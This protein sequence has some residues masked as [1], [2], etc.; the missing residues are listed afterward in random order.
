MQT[1]AVIAIDFGPQG[2]CAAGWIRYRVL[3]V[4]PRTALHHRTGQ[5]HHGASRLP[6]CGRLRLRQVSSLMCSGTV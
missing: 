1:R 2:W 4:R 3:Q 5:T 6:A